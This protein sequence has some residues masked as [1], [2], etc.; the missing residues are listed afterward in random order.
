MLRRSIR[1]LHLWVGLALSLLLFVFALTGGALVYKEAY[2]RLVYPE[3]RGPAP[4]LT[5]ADHAAAAAAAQR[6]FGDALGS[7]KLPEPGV[8]AYHAYL[9]E[10]EAFL[11]ADDHR[12]ID[13][14][15]PTERAMALLFDLHAHLMAGET[16]ER[17]GG[18]IGLLGALLAVSGIYLWWPSRRRFSL[19]GSVAPRSLAR[20]DLIAWHRDMGLLWSPLLLLLL[21]TAGGIVFYEGAGQ[22]LRLVLSD[23][24]PPA[25]V[26][27]PTAAAGALSA[28]VYARAAGVFPDARVVFYYPPADGES[29]HRFRLRR[30]CELHPN[31]RS[32]VT[33]D[34]AGTVLEAVDACALGAATRAQHA[35]YPLHAA[36]A[37]GALYKV[38]VFGASLV[39]AAL[40]LSGALAYTRKLLRPGA[41]ASAARDDQ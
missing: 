4:A 35:I 26:L 33:V 31:G 34:G 36:K 29:A 22:V 9:E 19:R 7:L 2:W 18:V 5:P 21:L 38:L 40:S 14:W 41:A 20:H 16:G 6:A 13:R 1:W 25:D 15:R 11:A 32:Y 39:L 23:G 27:P 10:G 37:T 17:V 3:L 30:D 12:V 24:P 8:N 28:G